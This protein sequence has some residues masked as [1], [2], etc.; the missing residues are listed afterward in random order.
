MKKVITILLTVAMIISL[1]AC[2]EPNVENDTL[3]VLSEITPPCGQDEYN[4]SSPPHMEGNEIPTWQQLYIDKLHEL[5]IHP[6]S[7]IFK[8]VYI[9]DND[10]PELII[11]FAARIEVTTVSNNTLVSEDFSP[12]GGVS[13]I[14]R[15]NIFHNSAFR[16]GEGF[17]YLFSIQDGEFMIIHRGRFV[18]YGFFDGN[19]EIAS[20]YWNDAEVTEEEYQELLA[21]AFD[22][23]RA[24]RS[25]ENV[26]TFDEILIELYSR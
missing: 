3:G 26:L 7:A 9:A 11:N 15:E 5:N 8:L 4:T 10:I 16:M 2:N 21:A 19:T 14:E 25:D 20:Y 23:D 18:Y 6:D 12:L 17:D 13:Y 22:F 24:V 1:N